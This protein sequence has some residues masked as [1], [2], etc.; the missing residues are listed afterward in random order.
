[1][2]QLTLFAVSSDTR[3]LPVE[4]IVFRGTGTNRTVT[5]TPAP[6]EIGTATIGITVTDP[7]FGLRTESF[8]VRVEPKPA[9]ALID[10]GVIGSRNFSY[11]TGINR[12]GWAVGYAQTQESDA[13]A[14]L[15][16]GL[17]G[18]GLLEDLGALAS[19]TLSQA[20]GISDNN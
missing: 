18:D 1:P 5:I 14:F 20:L 3:L 11:G 19:G 17:A 16:R 7:Q 6:G 2:D 10:L 4:N 12:R 15:S 13:T 9:Y 8:K